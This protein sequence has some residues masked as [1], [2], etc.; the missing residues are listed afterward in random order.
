VKA[1]GGVEPLRSWL[2]DRL[3]TNVWPIFNVADSLLLVGVAVFALYWLFQREGEVP[4]D[5]PT[6]EPA[7]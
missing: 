2:V 1:Y 4:S 7:A 6:P 3:G 5:D